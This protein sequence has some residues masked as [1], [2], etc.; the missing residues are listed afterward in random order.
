[1]KQNIFLVVIALFLGTITSAVQ[2]QSYTFKVLVSK[3]KSEVKSANVW[4]ALKI[5]TSLNA[6]DEI[7]VAENSY[8]GLIHATGKPV[9]VR[10]A[11]TYKVSDL[12]AK[13]G[14]GQSAINKY[15]DFILSK[16]EEKK[17]RLSATGAVTRE[18][19]GEKD[20]ILVYLPDR[21]QASVYGDNVFLEWSSAGMQAPYE[22]ILTSLMEDEL[23]RIEAKNSDY[24]LKLSEGGLKS[25]NEI[26][27][28]VNSKNVKGQGSKEYIIKKLR[29]ADRQKI[30]ADIKALD[31]DETTA[32]GQYYLAG[33]YEQNFLLID[34]LTSYHQAAVLAPDVELYKTT[35]TSFLVRMGFKK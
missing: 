21:Q 23:G 34:A 3:G 31:V 8:L 27:V 17:N 28:R 32:F 20:I 5:G 22:I 19:G 7:R 1:M 6:S 14:G 13:V 4:Q 11:K 18:V 30:E 29:P 24:I 25:E 10:D 33:F 35:Y 15:T 2:A 16:E 9:E 26:I 12:V